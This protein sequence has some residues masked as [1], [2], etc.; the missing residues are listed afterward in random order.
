M[1]F[2]RLAIGIA[3]TAAALIAMAFERGELPFG[4]RYATILVLAIG[5]LFI[6]YQLV[7]GR[8]YRRRPSM[9]RL[10]T[11]ERGPRVPV[12]GD[13]F[14][15]LLT[16]PGNEDRV[17]EILREVTIQSLVEDGG[18]GEDAARSA[19]LEGS[20]TDDPLVAAFLSEGVPDRTIGERVRLRVQTSSRLARIARRTVDE[21]RTVRGEFE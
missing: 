19:V 20:W 14:D 21:L 8:I 3:A 18:Y 9:A 10:P 7:E 5:A 17:R 15:Y 16:D 13:G 11:V 4:I 6:S 2:R 1:S 12:P